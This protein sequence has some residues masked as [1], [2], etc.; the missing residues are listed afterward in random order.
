M[1]EGRVD[2]R[3]ETKEVI[4]VMF[5]KDPDTAVRWL[6]I[7]PKLVNVPVPG[8]PAVVEHDDGDTDGDD[9]AVLLDKAKAFQAAHPDTD[10][11]TAL[12]AVK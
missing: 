9:R 2:A 1:F 12:E 3:P 10:I 8:P 5:D 11:V 4:R 6:S 7:A